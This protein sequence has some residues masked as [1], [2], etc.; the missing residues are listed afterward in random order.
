MDPTSDSVTHRGCELKNLSGLCFVK[1]KLRQVLRFDKRF[2]RSTFNGLHFADESTRKQGSIP[3]RTGKMSVM[4][5]ALFVTN[6]HSGVEQRRASRGNIAGHEGNHDQQAGNSGK[7]HR[8][9]CGHA[10]QQMR[11]EPTQ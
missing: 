2:V 4:R 1:R 8:I 11:H 6:R 5:G 3:I 10:E 7:R 9:V